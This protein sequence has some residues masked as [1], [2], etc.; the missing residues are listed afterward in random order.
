MMFPKCGT[1]L[2]YGSALV[3]RIFL[4]PTSNK[5]CDYLDGRVDPL[6]YVNLLSLAAP[7]LHG[8]HGFTCKA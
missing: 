6:S 1:L 3:M 4:A 8:S 5:L 2:T 7:H